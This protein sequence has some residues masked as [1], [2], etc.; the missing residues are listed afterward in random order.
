MITL[1]TRTN[2]FEEHNRRNSS[3]PFFSEYSKEVKG[4]IQIMSAVVFFGLSFVIQRYAMF[5]SIGPITFNACRFIISTIL[6]LCTKPFMPSSI[7]DENSDTSSHNKKGNSEKISVNDKAKT[8]HSYVYN[9][10]LWGT[11]CGLSNFVGSVL[12]QISLVTVT[13]GKVGFITGMYVVVVPIVEWIIPGFGAELNYVSFVA[14]IVSVIGL[15]L[16]SGCAEADVCIG[17]AFGTG[18]FLTFISVFCWVISLIGSDIGAKNVDVLSL[19]TIDFAITTILTIILALIMEP[20]YWQYPYHSIRKNWII[21]FAVGFTEAN[22]FLWGTLGQI[23]TPP[24]RAALLFSLESVSCAFLGY[25]FL[26]EQLTYVELFGCILMF[27][28]TIITSINFDCDCISSIFS[29]YT[30]T[31]IND[32]DNRKSNHI[33]NNSKRSIS[34]N[35]FEMVEIEYGVEG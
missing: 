17:G 11:V 22:A 1:L 8:S 31:R 27:T 13:A 12:Q 10:I 21:I 28:S 30:Y 2:S 33:S 24:T 9:L 34:S 29:N 32:N 5:Q 20:E 6:L 23:Y 16:I 25:I 26:H 3:S 19:V 35:G 4:E 18:E 7:I 14:A 15:Y